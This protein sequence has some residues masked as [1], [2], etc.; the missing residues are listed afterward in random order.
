MHAI[1]FQKCWLTIGN[2]IIPVVQSFLNK[3][4]ILKDLNKT[5]ITLIP[6]KRPPRRF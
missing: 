2:N 6:M 3:G 1:S 5:S 4:F